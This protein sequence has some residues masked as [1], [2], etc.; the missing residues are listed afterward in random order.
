MKKYFSKTVEESLKTFDV[1]LKGLTSEK[2]NKI[3]DSVGE[4]TLNEKRK[5]HFICISR[6]I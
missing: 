3:L 2:A 6:T 5:K 1:T 4:N